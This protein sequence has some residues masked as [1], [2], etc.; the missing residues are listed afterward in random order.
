MA[1]RPKSLVVAM[2]ELSSCCGTT[3]SGHPEWFKGG[4]S[5]LP[6]G[7]YDVVATLLSDAADELEGM[8]KLNGKLYRPYIPIKLRSDSSAV[9]QL[10][11]N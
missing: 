4:L 7:G 11:R 3:L 1:D 6:E 5:E 9:E 2:R 10:V 8:Q